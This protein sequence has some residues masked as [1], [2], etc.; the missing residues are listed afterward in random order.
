MANTSP[1]PIFAIIVFLSLTIVY[2]VV[3]Y[4]LGESSMSQIVFLIYIVTLILF[5]MKINLDVTKD[6]CGSS[7]WGTAFIVT[8]IPWVFIFGFLNVLLSIF[9]GWLIPFSNTFGYGIAKIAGIQDVFNDILAPKSGKG[10]LA[11]ALE[12][13]YNDSSLLLN[14]ITVANFDEEHLENQI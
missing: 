10:K 1:N 4:L 8:A 9:P 12:H 7:Q 11:E 6:M 14:E 13:I 5:E 3:K 2:F